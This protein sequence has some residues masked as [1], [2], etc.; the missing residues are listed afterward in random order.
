MGISGRSADGVK[1]K[2]DDAK[3]LFIAKLV[4]Q[5]EEEEDDEEEFCPRRRR[6]KQREPDDY[7]ETRHRRCPW[8]SG[9]AR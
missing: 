2:E 1:F 3:D 9:R 7:E 4:S 8:R 5:Q 6:K